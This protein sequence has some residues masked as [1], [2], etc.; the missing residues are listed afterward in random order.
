MEE[1]LL[2]SS[3]D[4]GNSVGERKLREEI[5]LGGDICWDQIVLHHCFLHPSDFAPSQ[6]IGPM[7]RVILTP[8]IGKIFHPTPDIEGKKCPTS[9]I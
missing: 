9:D 2:F 3:I 8:D 6:Q 4:G 1:F 7:K 5:L